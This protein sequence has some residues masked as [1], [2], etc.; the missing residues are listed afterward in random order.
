[1]IEI[2]KNKH[3]MNSID[4]YKFFRDVQVWPLTDEFNFQGWL[5]NFDNENDDYKI[6]CRIL[7]FFNYYT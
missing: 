5:S 3:T 1:M 6:A 2:E 7:N 4:R